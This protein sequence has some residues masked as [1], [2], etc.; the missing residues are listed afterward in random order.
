MPGRRRRVQMCPLTANSGQTRHTSPYNVDN[1]TAQGTSATGRY[2]KYTQGNEQYVI[3]MT[4]N[5]VMWR[6]NQIGLPT[7][8]FSHSDWTMINGR[9]YLVGPVGGNGIYMIDILTG[10]PTR[11]SSFSTGNPNHMS[12]RNTADLGETYGPVGNVASGQRYGFLI[13]SNGTSERGIRAFRMDPDGPL[14]V[15][16]YICNH[17]CERTGAS[18]SNENESEAHC[19]P[20]P[21]GRKIAFP[22]NWRVP[23]A[24]T[25]YDI[26]GYVA[27]IP[28]AWW[29][30][31]N[32]GS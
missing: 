7:N 16:R 27:L 22:S 3:D 4:T 6:T 29:S 12:C 25:D 21:D 11:I 26:H 8:N 10:T 30:Q 31:S 24:V 20:S 18:Y 9:E 1:A 17:R 19:Q 14:N 15:M 32:N 23:G 2:S 5:T 13:R 28:D